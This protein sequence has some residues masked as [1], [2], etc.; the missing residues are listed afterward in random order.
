MRII[1]L[2]L[3]FAS[4]GLGTAGDSAKSSKQTIVP[5][6]VISQKAGCPQCLNY[7]GLFL[8]AGAGYLIEGET[9]YYTGQ[10]GYELAGGPKYSQSVFLEVGWLEDNNDLNGSNAI[11]VT[12]NYE[13]KRALTRCLNFY[14]GGG[15]GVAFTDSDSVTES[16]SKGTG[17]GGT[18]ETVR[19]SRDVNDTVFF[20]QAFAGLTYCVTESIELYGGVRYLWSDD[21]SSGDGINDW[22]VGA[23]VRVKF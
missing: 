8:G 20:G 14:I 23:G 3:L 18:D 16:I 10:V 13:Y 9:V 7:S 1:A 11:P 22:S 4:A 15:V 19:N 5:A 17:P 2:P 12:L 6:S 21:I